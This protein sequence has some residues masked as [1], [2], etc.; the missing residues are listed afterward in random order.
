MPKV[1]VGS[2]KVGGGGG[3]YNTEANTET[4]KLEAKHGKQKNI[5]FIA[6]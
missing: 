6:Q 4:N 1:E 5:Y 2:N 3:Q